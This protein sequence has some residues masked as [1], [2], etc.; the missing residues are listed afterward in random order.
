MNWKPFI[1]NETEMSEEDFNTLTWQQG[2]AFL[3]LME[4]DDPE[5]HKRLMR[6]NL[7]WKWWQKQIGLLCIEWIHHQG[8]KRIRATKK[9]HNW[10]LLTMYLGISQVPSNGITSYS[11]LV[12][13][14]IGH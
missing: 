12:E 14:L 8:I 5:L 6:E 9:S 13:E 1:L 2:V 7:Y 11:Y 3:D 10:D 4:S